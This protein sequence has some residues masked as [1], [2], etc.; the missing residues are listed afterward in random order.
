MLIR[1]RS[2]DDV[3]ISSY[4]ATKTFA[5]TELSKPS[6]QRRGPT[7]G[8]DLEHLCFN[9]KL[10]FADLTS[11]SAPPSICIGKLSLGGHLVFAYLDTTADRFL[12]VASDFNE[13]GELNTNPYDRSKDEL[14][15]CIC[16]PYTRISKSAIKDYVRAYTNYVT[17]TSPPDSVDEAIDTGS[18]SPADIEEYGTHVVYDNKTK[19]LLFSM[20]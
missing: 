6:Y 2:H 7:N 18:V 9:H 1:Y 10:S 19:F 5:H 11:P 12:C 4:S 14:L 15:V 20:Q 3:A 8:P 13:W 17:S 16:S